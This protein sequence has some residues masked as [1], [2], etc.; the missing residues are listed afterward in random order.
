MGGSKTETSR[1]NYNDDEEEGV[2][3]LQREVFCRQPTLGCQQT[4]LPSQAPEKRSVKRAGVL[5]HL[6]YKE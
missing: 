3:V 1:E 2:S 5:L 4:K 6:I